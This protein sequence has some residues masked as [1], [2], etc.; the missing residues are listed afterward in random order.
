MLKPSPTFSEQL[1]WNFS[2]EGE[3]HKTNIYKKKTRRVPGENKENRSYIIENVA[4]YPFN[5]YKHNE[6]T[7]RWNKRFCLDLDITGF[8]N[9]VYMN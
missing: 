3:S 6:I 9:V 5:K 7:G 8:S 2:V 1:K 4:K